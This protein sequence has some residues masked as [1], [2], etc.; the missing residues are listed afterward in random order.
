MD[1]C[2]WGGIPRYER[3]PR[4]FAVLTR[5]LPELQTLEA[6]A[7]ALGDHDLRALFAADP[8]RA[9]RMHVDAAGWHLDYAKHRVT[10]ET[11]RLLVRLARGARLAGAGRRHVRGRARERHRR[12]AG[13]AHGAA[14][15]GGQHRSSSTASTSW[16][17]VH[18]V[19]EQMRAFATQVRDGD[20]ARPH[21]RAGSATS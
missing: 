4:L 15:A 8:S 11:M 21:R 18:A 16:R 14:D 5:S 20:V 7:A 13:A 3:V 12:P 17:E 2:V 10:D 19:L 9:E 1:Y 6:H